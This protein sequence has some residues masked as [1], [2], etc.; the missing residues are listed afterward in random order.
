M[1]WACRNK[2]IW[3]RFPANPVGLTMEPKDTNECV[4]NTF[5]RPLIELRKACHELVW[6]PSVMGRV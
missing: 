5:H 6:L 3:V 4:S 2:E 1:R